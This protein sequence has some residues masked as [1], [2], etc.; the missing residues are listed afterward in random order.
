MGSKWQEVSYTSESE[1]GTSLTV[2][3][4]FCYGSIVPV[5]LFLCDY[6]NS[7]DTYSR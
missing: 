1:T 4:N 5:S 7:L 6:L 2:Q 3:S